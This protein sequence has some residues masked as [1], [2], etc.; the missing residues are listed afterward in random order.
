MRFATLMIYIAALV[1]L[2]SSAV[3][4][5]TTGG[6]QGTIKDPSGA[7]VPHAQVVAQGASLVGTKTAE[8]DGSGYYRF[9]NLPPGAY[10]LTVSAKGFRTAKRELSLE[11]G[12]LPSVDIALEVGATSEVVEV[13]GETLQID[14]TSTHTLTNITPDI[15]KE[16]PHGLSF[17]SVI[18]FAPA[19]RNEPLEGNNAPG[20]TGAGAMTRP[21]T[22]GG[23]PGNT[24]NGG[25]F[26][27]QVAGGADSENRYL[28]E[29]QD[30]ANVAGG[31]SHSDVPFDFIDEVQI[32]SSGIEAE[33]GGAMGGVVNVIMKRGGNSWHGSLG[34]DYTADALT[35]NNNNPF[36]YYN[37]QQNGDSAHG[38][39][40]P[41]VI[42]TQNKNHYRYVQP[43]FSVGGP[44]LKDRLW[45]FVGAD[46]KYTST[47]LK[48]NFGTNDN[49]AG[50]QT[51]NQDQQTYFTTARLDAAVTQKIRLF[52]SWLYQLQRE[53]GAVLPIGDS[54]Q[55]L[56]N[57]TSTNPLFAYS[58]SL[59]YVAPNQTMNFGADWTLTPRLI[60]TVRFG[61]FFNNYHD[62][63]FP[64]G[65]SLLQ[66]ISNGQGATQ[67]C[68]P[69]PCTGAAL[70]SSLQQVSG[71]VSA[72]NDQN[73]TLRNADKHR[74]LDTDVAW[75]KGSGHFG[76]HNLKFGYQLNQVS[77]DIFQRWSEPDVQI[78]AGAGNFY[79]PQGPVGQTNC[80]PFVA[81]YKGCAGQDGYLTIQDFGSYGYATS[82]NHSFYA[83]DSI[84]VGRG[85]TV[86][87]GLRVE[88][89]S[90]PSET[91][92][93][94]FPSTPID[95]GWGDKIAPRIGVAWDVFR[96]GKMKVFGSYAV[97]NDLMKLNLAISSF[98]GQYWQNCA[99]AID[100]ATFD[101]TT[102]NLAYDAAGRYCSGASA[103]STANFAGG[104]VPAGLTFLENQN[105]RV[106][107]S[108]GAGLKPYR[109][110]ESVFGID[111]AIRSNLAFEARW[112]RRRLDHAIE[113]SSL[114][115]P[116]V[117]ETFL[118]VNPGQGVSKTYDG[119]FNTIYGT[120]SNCAATGC[121]P[122]LIGAV[123]SYDGVELRLTRSSSKNWF[124]MF[125]YTYSR[126]RGNYSGL[127]SSDL[128][129]GGGGRNAPNNSRAFDEPFFQF[130][131][132]GHS[133]SGPLGT[134]RPNAL[135]GY[136]Y[137]R[138]PW[139]GGKT[140][141][142]IGLFQYLYS[143][144]PKSTYADVGFSFSQAPFSG[145]FPVYPE[146]RGKWANVSLVPN[147]SGFLVPTV[148]SVCS[149][150]TPWYTQ[151]DLSLKQEF[152]VKEGQTLSFEV[153]VT[154]L[155]NQRTVTAY[156]SQIDSAFN[157]SFI[158]PSGLNL[159]AGTPAYFAYE[160][161]YDWK[162]LLSTNGVTGNSLYG[163]PLYYQNGRNMRLG[164]RYTF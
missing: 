133:S 126:L 142:N 149:C 94:G 65:G 146:G 11:V 13:S 27:F 40:P 139:F 66:F 137:Y 119:Y 1:L 140:S 131:A 53:S 98:G 72:A 7:V 43:L 82:F 152:K 148:T 135:K 3:A 61:Y 124:G 104:T 64:S 36:L 14:V 39:D 67:N 141:T 95:F 114:F 76:T 164:V 118:I 85:I 160:H 109:Q 2:V 49:N 35:A 28:V 136:G 91:K 107:E 12:H 112:D 99:Y 157:A 80:A 106:N 90:L 38:I 29:G 156:Y 113:D 62:F 51:F 69:A 123:R 92:A 15:I 26:G 115:N 81:K 96:S 17:Q 116:N 145:G 73:F 55:G 75:Y 97:Y 100:G 52:S 41:A 8:T 68:T 74:Q 93:S 150:R 111:Y 161:P 6:L 122:N 48:V 86:N 130:D 101:P 77:N 87:A 57:P 103:S 31:Y 21:G 153:N 70:P 4:Q 58:H 132:N 143:G 88:K 18:Q 24:S 20:G 46:P 54:A 158:S 37:P 144:A 30:T 32:K 42:Y 34:V 45:L 129:D 79:A 163:K 120:P 84:T 155:L 134:D 162:T 23:S 128:A 127:T 50:I 89:E 10:T 159:F 16:V 78:S 105:F 125:S 63:G 154:N 22:G 151:S 121:P 71:F 5:E 56:F 19:A 25:G 117:G 147:A 102:V 44:I 59:G 110:H 47:A 83:Q 108:V 33:H 9:A 60:A 138:I